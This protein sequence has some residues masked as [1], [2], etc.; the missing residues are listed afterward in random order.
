[1]KALSIRQPWAWLIVR[2]DLV[3]A[4]RAA[5]I[6]AGE[7]KD[8]ENRTWPTR[9]RGRVLVHASKSMTRAEYEDAEDPLW[10]LRGPTIQ[11]PPFEQ[12][13]RGG[14]VGVTTIDACVHPTE[15]TSLWHAEGCHGF[16][17][18][19]TKPLPFIECKGALQFFDVPADVATQ[20]RQMHNL[21][22]IV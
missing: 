20:L 11:L 2:P 5:A 8:I 17:L 15:R 14:I 4:A 12:L 16:R 21:G 3:G 13:Q 6:A 1:M 7:L 10:A 18:V 22:A 9:F 19:D